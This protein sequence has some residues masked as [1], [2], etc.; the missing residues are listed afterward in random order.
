MDLIMTEE[1]EGEEM[2]VGEEGEMVGIIEREE[3]IEITLTNLLQRRG[4]KEDKE[5]V[6]EGETTTMEMKG[7]LQT[8]IMEEMGEEMV[9]V[10][11]LIIGGF[12]MD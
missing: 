7:D 5:E 2:V 6:E 9:V 1:E 10:I 12:E 3:I 8:T 4:E 11:D